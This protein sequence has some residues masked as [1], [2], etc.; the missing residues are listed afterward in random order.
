MCI[1]CSTSLVYRRGTTGRKT[2]SRHYRHE[3]QKGTKEMLDEKAMSSKHNQTCMIICEHAVY[4]HVILSVYYCTVLA[5]AQLKRH[6]HHDT[7][8]RNF[9]STACAL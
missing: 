4:I 7:N 9:V 8:Y 5:N 6:S 2:E 1:I 3:H